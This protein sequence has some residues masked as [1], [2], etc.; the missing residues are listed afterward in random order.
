MW[1]VDQ[2][3]PYYFFSHNPEQKKDI[4]NKQGK[5]NTHFFCF[6]VQVVLTPPPVL[7]VRPLKILFF[8]SY[9]GKTVLYRRTASRGS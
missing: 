6:V 9:L 4:S 5:I 2:S 7:V 3:L 1:R 8:A